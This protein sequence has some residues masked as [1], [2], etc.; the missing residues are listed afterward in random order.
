[1]PVDAEFPDPEECPRLERV[2][3]EPPVPPAALEESMD[4]IDGDGSP[5]SYTA[6]VLDV[7]RGHDDVSPVICPTIEAA[8]GRCGTLSSPHKTGSSGGKRRD[9]WAEIE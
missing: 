3:L 7:Q 1:M 5:W 4:A 9:G 6:R 8:S 2:F